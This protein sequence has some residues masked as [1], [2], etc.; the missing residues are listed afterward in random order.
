MASIVR[1][2]PFQDLVS[3]QRDLGRMFG[4]L[5]GWVVPRRSLEE[6]AMMLTPTVDVIRRGEDL[7]FR[8]ELPGVKPEELDISVTQNMLTLKGERREEHE[9]KEEDYYM[10]ESSFGTFERMLRL[11]EGADVDHIKAE[12][13]NGILEVIIP[14]AAK[15]EPE[16]RHVAVSAPESEESTTQH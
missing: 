3:V 14:K 4:D 2:D 9:T 5:S 1:W 11:P 12:F 10:K 6:G 15:T 16:T 7:V 8:A 13:A